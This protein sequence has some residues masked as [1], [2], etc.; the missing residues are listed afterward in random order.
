MFYELIEISGM[1]AGR[2]AGPAHS[3]KI[4]P[5]RGELLVDVHLQGIQK[6]MYANQQATL[7]VQASKHIRV[8]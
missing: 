8:E 5:T 6:A 1:V 3:C 4:V 7:F 2:I